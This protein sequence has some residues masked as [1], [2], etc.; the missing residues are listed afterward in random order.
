MF[1]QSVRWQAILSRLFTPRFDD[2][3]HL[4][5]VKLSTI[6]LLGTKTWTY[7]SHICP[8]LAWSIYRVGRCEL[9]EAWSLESMKHV[10]RSWWIYLL[11]QRQHSRV[12]QSQD[13]PSSVC[14]EQSARK[15]ATSIF[16]S[17]L[18]VF[19]V[20]SGLTLR[21]SAAAGAPTSQRSAAVLFC[22]SP[23]QVLRFKFDVTS[24][25]EQFIFARTFY[26]TTPG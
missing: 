23:S 1:L 14:S 9:W 8:V 13:L 16:F 15:S 24:G 19:G 4:F 22:E 21:S 3:R 6:G 18:F 12:E 7:I 5:T 17:F 11:V 20:S 26:I 10:R 25:R 2:L